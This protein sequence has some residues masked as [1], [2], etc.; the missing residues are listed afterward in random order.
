MPGRNSIGR[1]AVFQAGGVVGVVKQIV[2][3]K[4]I[5]FLGNRQEIGNEGD[6]LFVF[7][8]EQSGIRRYLEIR[9]LGAVGGAGEQD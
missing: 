5:L 7:G 9:V 4:K 1:F 3:V 8:R 2:V 6:D